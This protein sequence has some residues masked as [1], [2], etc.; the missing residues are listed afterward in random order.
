MRKCASSARSAGLVG[1][2]LRARRYDGVMKISFVRR[3]Q[4]AHTLIWLRFSLLLAAVLAVSACGSGGGDPPAQPA[5]PIGRG[6]LKAFDPLGAVS[7]AD[8]ARALDGTEAGSRGL[9]PVYG[10]TSYRL[11][12][13]TIDADGRIVRASGL[14][15]VPDKAAGAKSPVLGYQHGTIFRNADAPSNNAVASE[16]AVVLASI[17]YIVAAPDYVGYG[18]SQG[19]P[20]P[21]LLAEPSAAAVVDFLTAAATWRRKNGIEDNGQLFL[22]GYSEG[23]YATMAAYR[24]LQADDA[25]QLQQLRTVVAGAGPYDVQTTLD[26]LLELV[27]DEQPALGALLDPGLL[28]YLGSTVRDELR[29]A[30]LRF[31]LPDDTD[32]TFD[33]RF[34]DNYLADDVGA[35][36]SLSS[37]HEWRPSLP[38]RLFHGRDDRTVPYA[39]SVS[40][41]QT[42]RSLGA[43][44]VV[45]LTDCQAVPSSH[46][47]CVPSFLG[48]VLTQFS[49]DVRDL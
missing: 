13:L 11:E 25:T 24:A 38:L 32:V 34:I 4:S 23:G 37:V 30:L 40:A 3:F 41:L 39:S 29:R 26:G 33:T 44:D 21:Y 43:G 35:I 1:F 36:A 49:G 27:R 18:V 16:I 8:V 14:V 28:R 10:V 20:H 12:Y 45:T 46:I 17:G 19:A 22:T 15:A 48:F 6:E 42:M 7:A 9:V 47:G 5:D 2:V 31:L